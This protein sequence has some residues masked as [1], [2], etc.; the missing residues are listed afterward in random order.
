MKKLLILTCLSILLFSC[1]KRGTSLPYFNNPDFT[2][3][4]LSKTD[5]C[6]NKLHKIPPFIFTDQN[7]NTI[8]QKNI[9]GKIYVANFFF[10]RCNNICPKM[11][12]NMHKIANTF[13]CDNSII[14]ISHSVTPTYDNVSVLKKY[15]ADK[16]ISNPNWHLVTGNRDNIY[17]IARNGYFADLVTSSA[18]TTQ[19][20]HTEN[21]I[22]VDK[23]K[24]IRGVYNGTLDVEVA[25]LVAHIK[26]LKEED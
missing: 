12:E 26:I 1:T 23:H 22:L 17:T 16:H 13:A 3:V 15:A 10:T 14:F 18:I 8:T 21:F 24:H 6:F 9:E 11:T 5:P 2:P 19:F 25:N 20:L 7:G 4:W